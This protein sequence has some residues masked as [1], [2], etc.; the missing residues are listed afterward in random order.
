MSLVRAE[1][2]RL[3][4]RRMTRWMLLLVLGLMATVAI[5]MALENQKPGPAAQ[6]EAEAAAAREFQEQQGWMEQEIAACE[7]AHETG[8]DDDFYPADCEEIRTWYPSQEEMVEWNLPPTF[9]FRDEFPAMITVFAALLSM[10]A[11]V[12]GA[13]VVGA[14][15]R[16]GGMMNL[17]LWRPRRLQVLGSK[18]TALLGTLVGL[19]V[20]LG[21]AWTAVFWLIATYRGVTDGMTD[22]TW[23]SLALTGVRGITLVL[24]AGTIGFAIASIGRHTAAA[25]GAAIAAIVV[26]VAGVGI[27]A[28]GLLQLQFFERWMWTTYVTAWLDKTAVLRDW[29][30]PCIPSGES[31]EC[32]VPQYEI[33]WQVA[34]VGMAVLVALLLG[35]AMWQ[36]RRRDVT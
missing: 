7:E 29:S 8:V 35:A 21:A 18:L 28:E 14:E 27:I 5:V 17:L 23:Q 26:G 19:G 30:V 2:R 31:G 12:V 34:G 6:A 9:E 25:M 4:K 15:W 32:E 3:S 36:I 13:S 10:F 33:T 24:V 20:L 11:F 1:L 16:T 22:G